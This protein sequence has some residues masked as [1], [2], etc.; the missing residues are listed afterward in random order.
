MLTHLVGRVLADGA[1]ALHIVAGAP[2]RMRSGDG[3]VPL[4]GASAFSVEQVEALLRRGPG[5]A[6]GADTETREWFWDFAELGRMRCC[7]F[8]YYRGPGLLLRSV[9]THPVTSRQLGLSRAI[10]ELAGRREGLVLVASPRGDSARAIVGALID[11]I[12]HTRKVHVISVEREVTVLYESDAALI[13]QREAGRGLERVLMCARAALREDPDVLVMDTVQTGEL[14]SLAFDAA[15]GGRLVV[16]AT[17]GASVV[18]VLED[19]V[20]LYPPAQRQRALVSCAR[21]LS[22]IVLEPAEGKAAWPDTRQLLLN[23]PDV[24][25]LVAEGRFGELPNGDA[26]R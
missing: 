18:G 19:V 11:L 12:N 3:L 23:T 20:S 17:R 10:E 26:R 15:R 14:M 9:P 24:A 6:F 8:H 25:R 13:S 2:P 16:A 7:S 4:P 5:V 21:A 22:A 1:S